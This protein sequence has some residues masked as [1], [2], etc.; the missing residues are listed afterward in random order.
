MMQKTAT[1]GTI[2]LVPGRYGMQALLSEYLEYNMF[3]FCDST[4]K[5]TVHSD[6]KLINISYSE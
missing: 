6:F 1:D 3:D 5:K 4:S 2:S